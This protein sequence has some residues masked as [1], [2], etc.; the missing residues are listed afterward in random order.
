MLDG[1]DETVNY[2]LLS[3]IEWSCVNKLSLCIVKALAMVMNSTQKLGTAA[4]FM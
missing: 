4:V 1:P 3:P 2:D